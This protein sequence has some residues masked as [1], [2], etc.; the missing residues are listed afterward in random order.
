MRCITT[1]NLAFCSLV[2]YPHESHCLSLVLTVEGKPASY[3]LYIADG[4]CGWLVGCI[5]CRRPRRRR[6]GLSRC[7][8]HPVKTASW[9][10]CLAVWAC[11]C[12]V[13]RGFWL[14]DHAPPMIPNRL[15][16]MKFRAE[17]DNL[18][19]SSY[20]NGEMQGSAG[21]CVTQLILRLAVKE[22]CWLC[23]MPCHDQVQLNVCRAFRHT[24]NWR[25]HLPR[26]STNRNPKAARPRAHCETTWEDGNR[27]PPLFGMHRRRSLDVHVQ[28]SPRVSVPV[29]P[30][31]C[32]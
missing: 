13:D 16:V 21:R 3:M 1:A 19:V 15:Q 25:V 12:N 23:V 22:L 2:K 20:T 14:E 5:R 31:W 9:C 8:F 28:R 18:E 29:Y 4:G 30:E 17:K 27:P 10:C 6:S 11:G 24:L 32:G 7:D 26:R